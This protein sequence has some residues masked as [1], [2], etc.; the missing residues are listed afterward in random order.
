M[1]KLFIGFVFLGVGRSPLFSSVDN[2]CLVF[3][4]QNII[5]HR[6]VQRRALRYTEQRLV[7]VLRI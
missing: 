5:Y 4:N 3:K 1:M 7:T 6:E 2:Y